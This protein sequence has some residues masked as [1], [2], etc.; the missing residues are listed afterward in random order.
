MLEPLNMYL[1]N[2]SLTSYLLNFVG[3][4]IYQKNYKFSRSTIVVVMT[5]LIFIVSN[6]YSAYIY[7]EDFEKLIFC[8]C[9]WALGFLVKV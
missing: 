6:S 1:E 4:D 7:R 9:T 5:I 8:I 3:L 2:L